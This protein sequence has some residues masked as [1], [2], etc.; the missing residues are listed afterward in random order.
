MK[1]ELMIFI[2][3]FIVLA[4]GMHMNQWLTH[5]IEH[6]A[7]LATDKMPYH[8]LLYTGV[9]YAS[10]VFLRFAFHLFLMPFRRKQ[11]Y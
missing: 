3:L 2:S 4:L 11:R 10:I 6:F 5:P 8:P 7:R 9:F 1:K